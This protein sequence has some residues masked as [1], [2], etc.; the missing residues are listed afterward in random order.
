[1]TVFLDDVDTWDGESY[2]EYE[3]TR[4]EIVEFAEQYDPQWFHTDPE[5]AKDSIYDGLIA[6]GWH[7][8]SASMRLFVDGFLSETA[9]L[10]AK[11]VDRLRWPHP[12]YPGDV[13]TIHSE[14]LDVDPIDD[15]RG[16]VR[17][18]VD[19]TTQDGDTVFSM[20]AL[21]LLERE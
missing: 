7:T 16:F 19:A 21:P 15:E 9:T 20:E 17:W 5:R 3:M 10:G 18:K 14:I 2:G 6:S 12:V 4:E 1:M 13:L 8:A 11:G